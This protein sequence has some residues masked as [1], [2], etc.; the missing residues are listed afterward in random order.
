[1]NENDYRY[2]RDHAQDLTDDQLLAGWHLVSSTFSDHPEVQT[3]PA[4][5]AVKSELYHRDLM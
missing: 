2:W 3:D 1:M 5:R 4:V